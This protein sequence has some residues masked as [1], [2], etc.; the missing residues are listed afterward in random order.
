M[1]PFAMPLV[2]NRLAVG[3]EE[4]YELQQQIVIV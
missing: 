2:M 3:G 1:R 4:M